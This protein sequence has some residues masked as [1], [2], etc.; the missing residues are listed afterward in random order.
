MAG[1]CIQS[2]LDNDYRALNIVVVDNGSATA[3]GAELKA[4]FPSI[5]AVILSG[6]QG[7][8]GGCNRGLE[9]AI[10]KNAQYAFLLNND[11]IVERCAVSNLVEAL[12]Q[13]TKAAAASSLILYPGQEQKV[14]FYTGSILRNRARHEHAREG[15]LFGGHSW[16]TVETEFAPACATLFR[17]S[18]LRVVGLFDESF[19]TCWEDYDLCIRILNAGRT[20]ITVGS[21]QVVH[22]HGATT[23]RVSPYITYYLTRNRM[24][25]LFRYG[26][27]LGIFC[28]SPYILRTFWW[29]IRAYG[30][31]N[32]PC[33]VA[34]AK[35]MLHFL[36]GIRGEGSSQ[37]SRGDTRSA[38]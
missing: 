2:L 4:R 15:E 24:I 35:G 26:S 22:D 31:G 30:F 6:N 17:V 25:C 1:Q 16:P 13:N 20:L 9:H 7:F 29:Q 38:S 34:F 32:W 36:F 5:E 28:N 8:T 33:H 18:D 11:T 19:G 27:L 14:Q 23:G 10:D 37:R 12:E 3:C 21:A